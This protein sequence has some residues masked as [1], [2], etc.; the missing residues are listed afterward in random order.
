MNAPRTMGFHIPEDPELLKALGTVSV[1]HA[2]LDYILKMLIKTLAGLSIEDALDATARDGSALLRDRARKLAKM[3]LGEGEPLLLLQ[4]ILERC[5]R[6][7]AQRNELIHNVI[8][9]EID[10]DEA[11]M[12]TADRKRK[13]LPAISDL[14]SLA[15]ELIALRGEINA[16]RLDG[17]LSEALKARIRVRRMVTRRV[18]HLRLP[19]G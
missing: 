18:E 11:V 6:A 19:F 7:T 5:G 2:H 8:I 1:C 17:F 10:S 3:K 9:S 15:S 13:P 16:A 14:D 4:A 12:Q